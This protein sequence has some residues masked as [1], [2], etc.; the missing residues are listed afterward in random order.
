VL[1]AVPVVILIV[2]ALP[3]VLGLRRVA[4][5]ARALQRSL[6][7]FAEL[8]SPISELSAEARAVASK[9][10]ELRLRTRPALPPAP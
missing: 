7:S 4:S 6:A 2:M 5:D 10:P 9:V 3:V 8:R 1:W